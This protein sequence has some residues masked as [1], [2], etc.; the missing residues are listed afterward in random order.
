MIRASIIFLYVQ[1]FMTPSF[2]RICYAVVIFNILFATATV[3]ADC[4]ICRPIAYR[5]DDTIK[6]GSCGDSRAVGLYTGI[7]NL[8]QDV[9]VVA[10]PMPVLW[11]LQL[12]AGRKVAVTLIFGLGFA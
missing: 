4:L 2:R 7:V 6:G 5:W 11:R 3:L 8:F 1:I 12:A 9:L 10:L